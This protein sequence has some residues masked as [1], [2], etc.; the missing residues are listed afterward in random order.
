MA[1]I[2]SYG[3]SPIEKEMLTK[4]VYDTEEITFLAIKNLLYK[5]LPILVDEGMSDIASCREAIITNLRVKSNWFLYYIIWNLKDNR[6]IRYIKRQF[7]PRMLNLRFRFVILDII[8]SAYYD[9]QDG[10]LTRYAEEDI[11]L[12]GMHWHATFEKAFE[13]GS[14]YKL[15]KDTHTIF[16]SDDDDHVDGRTRLLLVE[17]LCSCQLPNCLQDDVMLETDCIHLFKHT[18]PRPI[19]NFDVA[20]GKVIKYVSCSRFAKIKKIFIVNHPYGT[21]FKGVKYRVY[22]LPRVDVWFF[23]KSPSMEEAFEMWDFGRTFAEKND[24]ISC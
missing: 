22:Y 20:C 8:S 9:P 10:E 1:A 15:S 21:Y 18:R 19:S 11:M 6:E 4:L 7:A 5:V 2:Y 13:A 12:K 16:M 3:M 24:K 14:N 17:S 23:C